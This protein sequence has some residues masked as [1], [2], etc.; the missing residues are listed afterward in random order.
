MQAS[1][2]F[3][4]DSPRGRCYRLSVLFCLSTYTTGTIFGNST[5]VQL[6]DYYGCCTSRRCP[7]RT[8]GAGWM[9]ERWG[10]TADSS[11]A[12]IA[13]AICFAQNAPS[14]GIGVDG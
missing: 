9:G 12:Q 10:G 1:N 7:S 3:T 11:T 14:E 8:P 6:S 13:G 2:P 5:K 4:R